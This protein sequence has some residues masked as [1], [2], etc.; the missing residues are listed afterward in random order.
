MLQTK[1]DSLPFHHHRIRPNRP[2]LDQSHLTT[3]PSFLTAILQIVTRNRLRELKPWL[4]TLSLHHRDLLQHHSEHRRT[5]LRVEV[6]EVAWDHR[7]SM[8]NEVDMMT[9]NQAM[10]MVCGQSLS[11]LSWC[12]FTTRDRSDNGLMNLAALQLCLQ[13]ELPPYRTS[14]TNQRKFVQS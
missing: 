3:T 11:V 2:F 8:D 10:I 6:E 9:L 12:F 1:K 5:I 14:A 4:H 7:R 13:R